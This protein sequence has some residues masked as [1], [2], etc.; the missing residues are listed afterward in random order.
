M[1]L[2]PGNNPIDVDTRAKERTSEHER[3]VA[4]GS[5]E[6]ELAAERGDTPPSSSGRDQVSIVDRVRRWFA[7][8]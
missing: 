6:R 2:V 5:A 1:V 3:Q 8:R 7:R 4:S